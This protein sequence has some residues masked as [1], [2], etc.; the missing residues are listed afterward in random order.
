M[1]RRLWGV[2]TRCDLVKCADHETYWLTEEDDP[3]KAALAFVRE[4]VKLAIVTC[5]A[6]GAVWARKNADGKNTYGSIPAPPVSV[7][8]TTGAGDAFMS[9]LVA[10]LTLSD[11]TIQA[12]SDDEITSALTFAAHIGSLAVTQKGAVHGI[13]EMST[14]ELSGVAERVKV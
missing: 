10:R 14:P 12:L 11:R 6:K 1:R 8:D 3:L 9:A 13:P 5:G 7:V 2:F 4:G